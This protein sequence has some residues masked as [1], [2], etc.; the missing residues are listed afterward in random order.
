MQRAILAAVLALA[1]C[2]PLASRDAAYP[3]LV[4]LDQALFAPP[5]PDPSAGV[6][7][8]AGALRARAAWLR[9]IPLG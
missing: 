3:E 9:S 5:A 6:A 1:A 4:P 2:A 7:A 8:R